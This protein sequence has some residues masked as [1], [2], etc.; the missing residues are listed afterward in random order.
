M[1]ETSALAGH[2]RVV[3]F[4]MGGTSTDVSHYAGELERTSDLL[5]SKDGLGGATFTWLPSPG[6]PFHHLNTVSN[7]TE[8]VDP[9]RD[10][11][12]GA[13]ACDAA[14]PAASCTHVD[15]LTSAEP[16]LYYRA[17]AACGPNG[18]DEGPF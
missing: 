18:D 2:Q 10:P 11:G 4:D 15:A 8:L 3:G 9:R 16:L 13:G 17:L 5:G 6:A 14:A 12:N 7:K 1:I